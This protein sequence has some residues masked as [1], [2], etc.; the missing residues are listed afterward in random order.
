MEHMKINIEAKITS[1]PINVD[2]IGG[3]LISIKEIKIGKCGFCK[4]KKAIIVLEGLPNMCDD[5]LRMAVH[6]LFVRNE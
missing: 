6:E 4:K 3:D 1:D 2:E 5:C